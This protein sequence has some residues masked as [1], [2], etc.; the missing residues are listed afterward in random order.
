VG[1]ST[2]ATHWLLPDHVPQTRLQ[3]IW[4][5]EISGVCEDLSML[6]LSISMGM[7]VMPAG[8][9]TLLGAM[10]AILSALWPCVKTL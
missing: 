2:R 1:V 10:V 8:V 7:A 9:V 6:K 5:S 3:D 4:R